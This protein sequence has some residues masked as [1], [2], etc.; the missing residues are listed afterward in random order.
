MNNTQLENSMTIITLYESLTLNSNIPEMKRYS[1]M[2][3]KIN[4][5]TH[6]WNYILYMKNI[7]CN[8]CKEEY[9]IYILYTHFLRQFIYIFYE[10]SRSRVMVCFVVTWVDTSRFSEGRW[11][12]DSSV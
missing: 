8:N 6:S 2:Y 11:F 10:S 3:T 7:Q 12:P 4:I 1:H 5:L 9:N